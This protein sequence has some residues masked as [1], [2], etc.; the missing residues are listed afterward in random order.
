M[1]F[2]RRLKSIICDWI[3]FGLKKVVFDRGERKYHG[4]VKHLA[5]AVRAGGLEF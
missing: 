5:E 3:F 1:N 4:R 2:S